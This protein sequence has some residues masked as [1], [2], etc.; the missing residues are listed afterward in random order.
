LNYFFG[1]VVDII[2][3][4]DRIG[5][6]DKRIKTC[7]KL[8]PYLICIIAF[9][10]CFLIN[11]PYDILYEPGSI[12]VNLNATVTFTLWTSLPTSFASSRLAAILVYVV[13][14]LRDIL[15]FVIQISLNLVSVFLLKRYLDKK[16]RNSSQ[17]GIG[18]VARNVSV[19]RQLLSTSAVAKPKTSVAVTLS[20]SRDR[21]SRAELRATL[22]VTI[23][24]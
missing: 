2:I 22:M 13:A 18:V 7:I 9:F 20:S 10:G 16:K 21:I 1:S 15:V 3:L 8:P 6:F 4:L 11:F 12:T 19:M 5:H 17:S 14:S 24:L 23:R